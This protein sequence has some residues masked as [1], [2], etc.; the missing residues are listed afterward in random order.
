MLRNAV[1]E[2]GVP[3]WVRVLSSIGS[4]LRHRCVWPAL[5]EVVVLWPVGA[6]EAMR[7]VGYRSAMVASYYVV[8]NDAVDN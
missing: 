4:E 2:L 3:L 6:I 5:V 7:N 8:V 1:V